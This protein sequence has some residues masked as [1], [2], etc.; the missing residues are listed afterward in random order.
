MIYNFNI[1]TPA[2]TTQISPQRTDVK[3][4]RGVIHRIRIRFPPGS[5]GKLHAYISRGL[6]TIW[7]TNPEANFIGDNEIIDF[8]ED[9]EVPSRP[10]ILEIYTWN[11]STTKAHAIIITI[12]VLPRKTVSRRRFS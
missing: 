6:N 9:Y 2:N 10:T 12:G 3:L 4:T 11:E 5:A 8:M 1:S 7:P